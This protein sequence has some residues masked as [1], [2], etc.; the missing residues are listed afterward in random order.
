V[1]CIWHVD[2]LA[3]IDENGEWASNPTVTFYHSWKPPREYRNPSTHSLARLARAVSGRPG[4]R[5]R[6]SC[7]HGM[8]G[9]IAEKDEDY[10][11]A[12]TMLIDAAE[13]LL[14]EWNCVE[15]AAEV[16]VATCLLRNLSRALDYA[17]NGEWT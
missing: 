14:A 16:V 15:H 12:P 7:L 13:E 2:M 4:W 8:V 1:N 9:W 3:R 11:D 5:V 10:A 6:P 17:N